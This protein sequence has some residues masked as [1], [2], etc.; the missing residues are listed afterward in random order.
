MQFL[1]LL[2]A[3]CLALSTA[4]PIDG[5]NPKVSRNAAIIPR[6]GATSTVTDPTALSFYQRNLTKGDP[7]YPVPNTYQCFSGPA[8]TFNSKVPLRHWMSFES[9]FALNKQYSLLP[10]GDTPAE[11]IAIYNAIVSVSKVAKVDARVILAVVIQ[12]STGNVRVPCTH[13]SVQNCG[14]MQSYNPADTAYDP[15]NMQ[16]SITQMIVDGTQGTL[17][18]PGLVQ[19]FN[20]QGVATKGNLWNVLRAY[21][22]GCVNF[23]NLSDGT[24]ATASYVSDVANRLLGWNGYGNGGSGCG[25]VSAGC[26]KV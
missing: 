22:S 20:G 18:G 26:P 10:I 17:A 21:N 9:M 8:A 16:A 1:S 11:A 15:N 25:L 24:S 6:N 7:G 12:E 13:N 23:N 5:A 2:L 4:L 14:L 3:S 19:L